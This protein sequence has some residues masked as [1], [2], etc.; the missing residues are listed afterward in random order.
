[1]LQHGGVYHHYYGRERVTHIIANNLPNSKVMKLTDQ[2]VV[3]PAWITD[4]YGLCL[5]AL[6][7]RLRSVSRY[8]K[9]ISQLSF[10][11]FIFLC[12]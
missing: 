5:K 9:D 7:K 8:S 6:Y 4:R 11:R 2:K 3:K 1:M 10:F 12:S